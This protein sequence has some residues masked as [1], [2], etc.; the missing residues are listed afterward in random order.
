MSDPTIPQ[1]QAFEAALRTGSL[2]GAARDLGISQQ[3]ASTAVRALE[4]TV[5]LE[6]LRRSHTGVE[7]TDSGEVF[8]AWSREVLEA[9][10]RLHQGLESLRQDASH[11]LAVGASQTIAAH[12][13][14]AWLLNLRR[15]QQEQGQPVTSIALQT[16]NSESI[17]AQ[18]REGELDLGFIESPQLPHGLGSAIVYTDRMVVAVHPEHPWSSRASV[19]L[20]DVATTPLVTREPGSGTRAAFEAAVTSEL[21]GAP[22]PPSLELGTEAAIREAVAEGVAPAVLSEL[23]VDDDVRLGRV[24]KLNFSP[25]DVTRPFAAIWRGNPRDLTGAR[26]A[27]VEVASTGRTLSGAERRG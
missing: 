21:G 24:K 2:S 19:G 4:R 22:K 17:V 7:V 13:L 10:D 26:R 8:L 14:P 12:L 9:W 23:S 20:R 3:A 6:L 1:L 11:S 27:L 15:R 25:R 5:Q 18:V 16:A